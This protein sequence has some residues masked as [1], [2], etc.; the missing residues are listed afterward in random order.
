MATQTSAPLNPTLSDH[1]QN[2][3]IEAAWVLPIVPEGVILKDHA[4]AIRDD[5][6]IASIFTIANPPAEFSGWDRLHLTEHVLLPGLINAHGHAAMSL[7]RG[8]ADDLPLHTWLNDHIWPAEG[9]HVDPDFVS[10]GTTLA[11][12]EMLSTGTTCM[13]DSYFFPDTVANTC[14]ET[15]IRAQI[16][17]PVVQ[18]PNAWAGTEA[19]HIT[20]ALRV[21]DQFKSDRHKDAGI[22]MAFAPHAPY[23]VSDEAF[24]KI[25]MYSEQLEIPIHLHLHETENEVLDAV[26]DNNQRPFARIAAL[27]LLSP[28]LQTVHMTE[29]VAEEMDQMAAAGVHVAHCPQ[30]NLK[31]ASGFCPV[32]ELTQRGINV[33]I[34]T[35]SAA[36]N[37]NLDMIEETRHAALLAKGVSRDATAVNAHQAIR[38][39]TLNGARMLGIEEQV[40]SLELGKR[41][42]VIAV[43]LSHL[44]LQPV[45]DPVSQLVYAASGHQVSHTWV[46]GHLLYH[47]NQFTTIDPARLQAR[48]DRWREQLQS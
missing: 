5:G 28:G 24:Q 35:D 41:A 44:N 32:A 29:L 48:V 12:A 39:A 40:G 19:E 33:A 25:L 13:V 27:G 17:L 10:D 22:T 26:R 2:L 36:S 30:S 38:M 21:F 20:K 45:H 46:N 15:G 11:I 6:T 23:T 37:N 42:D 34:G 18:F 4:V 1:R 43:E 16:S 7:L 14:M 3:V 9:K 8:Y 31:L 47:E